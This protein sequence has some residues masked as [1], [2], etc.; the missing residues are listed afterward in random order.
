MYIV[1][2]RSVNKVTFDHCIKPNTDHFF[3]AL[4]VGGLSAL[5]V[6]LHVQRGVAIVVD[7]VYVGSSL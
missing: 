7:T 1:T 3:D 5:P 4:Q 6:T 2:K